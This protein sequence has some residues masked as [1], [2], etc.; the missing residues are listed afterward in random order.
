MFVQDTPAR[1]VIW[2][3]NNHGAAIIRVEPLD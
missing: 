2:I 1:P 3:G